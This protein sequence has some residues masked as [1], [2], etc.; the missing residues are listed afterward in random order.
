M[1]S[2]QLRVRRATVDDLDALK[3]LWAVMR[4]PM[5]E[6]ERRLTEFQIAEDAGGRFA[7]ALGVQIVRQHALL[8]SEDYPNFADADAARE[9][10]WDRVRKI[11]ANHGV[12]RIWTQDRSPFWSRLGFFPADSETLG[13]LPPEWSNLEG[14]WF[15]LELKNEAVINAALTNQFAEFMA[16][17]KKSA[18]EISAKAKTMM[19]FITAAGFLIFFACMAILAY[20]VTHH[21]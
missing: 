5:D 19:T 1:T 7:G 3:P 16:A 2:P 9:L 6:M 10:F 17:E 21:H 15:T 8:H 18:E 12:F 20:L 11:A 14:Q 4:L 13:R